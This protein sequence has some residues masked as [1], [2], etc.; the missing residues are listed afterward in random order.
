PVLEHANIASA[1]VAVIAISDYVASRQITRQI[2][3]LNPYL[4]LIVRTRFV[5]EIDPLRDLGAD[6]V[7]PEEYETAVEIFIRVLHHYLVPQQDIDRFM[8]EVRAGGYQ[9]LR[10][11]P[12]SLVSI[13]DMSGC[14]SD[15][16]MKVVQ[17]EEGSPFAGKTIAEIGMRR[18]YGVNILA[19]RRQEKM[20]PNPAADTQLQTGDVLILFGTSE[21]MNKCMELCR[22]A[23]TPASN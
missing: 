22:S 16:E 23:N 17:L 6:E 8:T 11:Q 12:R 10:A 15:S 2:K 18:N 14:L 5:S 7:I 1:R 19:I 20:E 13:C 9:M 3:E 4:H 21:E